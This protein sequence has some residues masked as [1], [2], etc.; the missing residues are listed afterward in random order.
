MEMESSSKPCQI[1]HG[2]PA[3]PGRFLPS[4]VP[5]KTR[6]AIGAR[7]QCLTDVPLP[8][9]VRFALHEC[10]SSWWQWQAMDEDE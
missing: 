9:R 5:R 10:F 7:M 6:M 1:M 8:L 2:A 4:I 3:N